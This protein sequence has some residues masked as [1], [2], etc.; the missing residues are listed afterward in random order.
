[1]QLCLLSKDIAK[2]KDD[3]EWEIIETRKALSR[4]GPVNAYNPKKISLEDELM[5]CFPFHSQYN[6][7]W[8]IHG[9]ISIC[10]LHRLCNK[11]WTLTTM[12]TRK[13]LN[14]KRAIETRL[15]LWT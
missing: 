15:E 3:R 5:V 6:V 8:I 14:Q 4:T 1:M 2:V 7:V 11:R 12:S 10:C 9:L 13:F